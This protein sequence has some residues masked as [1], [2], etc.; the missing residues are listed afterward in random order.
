LN[1]R[2][3]GTI[4]PSSPRLSFRVLTDEDIQRIYHATLECLERTGVN[5][6]NAE[7]RGLLVG[8]GARLDGV[9]V[10]IPRRIIQDAVAS[11]PGGF[12]LW[13]RDPQKCL[14]IRPG[15]VYFGPGLT[16]G[17]F[18]DPDTGQRRRSAR[19]DVALAA[20]VVDALAQFDYCMGMALPEDVSPERAAVYEFAEMALNC[21]KPLMAWGY[22]LENM[23]EI[24]RIAAAVVGGEATLRERPLYALF[25][26][27]LGPLVAPDAV[28]ANV[29]W[30]A[31]KGIPVVYHG[32]GVA[33]ASAPIT[34][35]GTLVVTL[36]GGLA[37]LA[38]AQLKRPG[39]AFCL[40]TVP[41]AMDPRTARPA[42][43]GPEMSL[44]AAAFAEIAAHLNIPYMGVAGATEAKQ[45]DAQAAIESTVQVIFALLSGASLPHD[46][47]FID[48]GDISSLEMLVMT[49]EI[50][51]LA[52]RI[53]RGIEVNDDTLALDLI[54]RVGPGGEFLSQVETARKFR[55][56]IWIPRLMDRQPWGEWESKGSVDMLE[57]IRARIREIRQN[58]LPYPLPEGSLEAVQ[59]ILG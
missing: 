55:Q 15:Q 30:A 47:G 50:I 21:S 37:G 22:S 53:M 43:G 35:A 29:L 28:M 59:T 18:I 40:G 27:G 8:A 16:A 14:D 44:Y 45:V 23:H 11:A 26:L 58:H 36:A 31:E 49:D 7:G 51:S 2:A 38:I 54:D 34:A 57:R 20:R 9:R 52:R 10:R 42:Y 33:G 19:Q 5:V 3:E 25:A 13:G 24:D 48:C 17:Y 1:N 41:A 4:S 56:E 46:A 32:P 6:L 39:A 12:H